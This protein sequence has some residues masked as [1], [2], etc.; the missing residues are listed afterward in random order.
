M[1]R[2]GDP[3]QLTCAASVESIRWSI[4][5]VNEHGGDEEFTSLIY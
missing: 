2:V 4:V 3:L 5:V 1:C